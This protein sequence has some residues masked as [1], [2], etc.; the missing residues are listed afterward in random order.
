MG[1]VLFL[2]LFLTLKLAG[3]VVKIKL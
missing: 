2:H 3:W 1:V